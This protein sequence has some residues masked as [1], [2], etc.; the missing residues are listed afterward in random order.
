ML[1]VPA[2]SAVF[3]CSKVR[4]VHSGGR[5]G[6]KPD[7]EKISAVIPAAAGTPPC[8]SG[9]HR[10]IH[11]NGPGLHAPELRPFRSGKKSNAN[12]GLPCCMLQMMPNCIVLGCI[13]TDLVVVAHSLV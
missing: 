2:V 1:P 3:H 12:V 13:I 4:S 7:L 11:Q 5:S 8:L 6:Q 10:M 9:Q